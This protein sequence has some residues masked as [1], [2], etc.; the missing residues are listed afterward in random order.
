MAVEQGVT[1]METVMGCDPHLDTI[2]ASVV[3][4]IGRELEAVTVPNNLTGWTRLGQLATDHQINRVGI[5]GASGHGVVL[6]RILDG[7]GF[8]VLEIPTRLT[9]RRRRIDGAG[10]TDPGDARTIARAVAA[11]EGHR[12]ADTPHLETIRVLTVRRE[13]LVTHQ[14][15]DINQLRALMAELDPERAA[16]TSRLRSS[17]AI[18]RFITTTINQPSAY[19]QTL[20]DLIAEIGHTC[21][22]RLDRIRHLESRMRKSLP[23]AGH[24]LI[25][26]FV[27]CDLITACQILS[28][29]AG[30]DGFA[31][32]AKFAAW[33]GT[34]PLD[35]SSGRQQH[36]RLNRGG[37][38][39]A[40]RAIH[41]I[42]LTQLKH[43]GQAR[44]YLQQRNP[45]NNKKRRIV[46]RAAKRHVAR[47]VWKVLRDHGLT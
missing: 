8:E 4:G 5:E 10:K 21:L 34:A 41:T 37:N 36:H 23:A 44:H 15:A 24:A 12:W 1:V 38:R 22:D 47:Q 43:D 16:A 28:Q 33:S 3:D 11:G 31:T 13:Q 39:Q 19:Q 7:V 40:N 35:V 18:R 29:T 2:S 30:I 25:H 6:S 9:A 14:T 32:D 42:V 45:A 26:R 46:I 17:A 20:I 27:G